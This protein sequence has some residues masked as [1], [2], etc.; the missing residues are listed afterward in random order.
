M[1]TSLFE[2]VQRLLRREVYGA[3]PK[4]KR[5]A[6][7]AHALSSEVTMVP[8]SRLM[9]LIGQA[10]KW[11]AADRMGARIWSPPR[12]AS[13]ASMS[14]SEKSYLCE[15]GLALRP[16]A[17]AALRCSRSPVRHQGHPA[18]AVRRQQH[19]G[20]LPPGTAFD[21]FRGQA[22]GQ[23]DEVEAHPAALDRSIKFGKKSHPEVAAFSPDGQLLVTGSVDGFVEVRPGLDIDQGYGVTESSTCCKAIDVPGVVCSKRPHEGWW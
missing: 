5:R 12:P 3:M 9:A 23:R 17:A 7:I 16:S 8:P 6:Q 22:Q 15:S 4:D 21:L 1:P 2:L 18:P 11:C 10:L 20:L 13:A 14:H 19:Q